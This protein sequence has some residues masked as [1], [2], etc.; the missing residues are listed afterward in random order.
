MGRKPSLIHQAIQRLDELMAIGMS[1]YAAKQ[2]ARAQA[3]AAGESPPWTV[4]DGKIH[5]YSARTSYQQQI[6]KFLNW[7]RDTQGLRH[8]DQIDARAGELASRYLS[9]QI[10]AGK[11]PYTLSI[12][13]AALRMF[14]GDRT[15]ASEV[16]LPTRKREGIHRSRGEAVRDTQFQPANHQ[17]L[18]TFL[19][20]CGLRR[21]EVRDLRVA[22]VIDRGDHLEIHVKNGKGGRARDVPV[23]PG[24]AASTRELVADRQGCDKVFARVPVRLD[25]HALRREF[26]QGMYREI[27]ERDLPPAQGRLK[28]SD[29]DRAAVYLVSRA[30]GHNRMDVVL[31]HYLR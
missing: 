4:T 21:S 6:L 18:I 3:V 26:A 13:R 1:R 24:Y 8:L 30:L 16:K 14:F 23:R 29:Y 19:R 11:S 12:Q 15:L 7:A 28:P 27:S 10:A 20:G 5:S 9:D 22:D 2:E 31:N 17:G 25:V